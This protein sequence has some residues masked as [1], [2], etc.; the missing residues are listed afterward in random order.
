[1]AALAGPENPQG[2]SAQGGAPA[3]G[4]S[5]GAGGAA[6]PAAPQ[7][8]AAPAPI[9]VAVQT[10]TSNSSASAESEDPQALPVVFTSGL[11]PIQNAA[12]VVGGL[13]GMTL[14]AAGAGA[15]TFRGASMQKAR[16][17]AAR[18]EFL[19]PRSGRGV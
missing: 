14:V 12:A 11:P 8:L 4:P 19:A 10:D 1:M 16:L 6:T 5:G 17:T 9:A 15:L 18:A 13:A 7:I 3:P 2:P